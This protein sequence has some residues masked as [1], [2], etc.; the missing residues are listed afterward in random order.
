MLELNIQTPA[1]APKAYYS[2]V[3]FPVYPDTQ[4]LLNHGGGAYALLS[5]TPFIPSASKNADKVVRLIDWMAAEESILLA[6]FGIEEYSYEW[7]NDYPVKYRDDDKRGRTDFDA[8]TVTSQDV[9]RGSTAIIP[10]WGGAWTYSEIS[11]ITPNYAAA[12]GYDPK[13]FRMEFIND[14]VGGR[15]KR[16]NPSLDNYMGYPSVAEMERQELILPDLST[17]SSELHTALVMGTK[18]LDNWDAYMADLKRLG[19]DE[20]IGI[21]Q[22]MAD[23]VPPIVFPNL[24]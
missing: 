5:S 24:N 8:I 21:K 15:F 17:Y 19:L 11:I 18:S 3:H 23:K 14:W 16:F 9:W 13:T 6:Q 22:R 4:A 12:L 20:L 1:G 2:P 10:P 7:V